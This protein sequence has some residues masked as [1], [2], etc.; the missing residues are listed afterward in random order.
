MKII[1]V[2]GF[3]KS[4]KTTTSINLIKNLKN[5]G[6]SVT[7]A[8]DIHCENITFDEE[9]T[10]TDKALKAGADKV[11][12][13]S[14]KICFSVSNEEKSLSKIVNE[15]KTDFL[16]LEGFKDSDYEKVV[17]L[18]D[19]ADLK[20]IDFSNIVCYSGVCSQSGK[21]EIGNYKLIDATKNSEKIFKMMCKGNR[22]SK[23]K[24]SLSVNGKVVPMIDYVS[25]TFAD[26]ILAYAK[27]LKKIDEIKSLKI[28][29]DLEEE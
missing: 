28:E 21:Q 12:G 25:K 15:A 13:S 18:K 22:E 14:P 17:C 6:F 29:I 3:S 8:K 16:I 9:N 23:M 19:E 7:Y 27:N 2:C 11:I 4:G 1:N 26:V 24:I 5:K 10:D 20:D